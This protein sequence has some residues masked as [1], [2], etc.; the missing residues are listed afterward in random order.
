MKIKFYRLVVF[1]IILSS[2][3]FGIVLDPGTASSQ[4]ANR[5]YVGARPLGLGGSFAAVTNDANSIFWNPAGLPFLQRQEVT[6]M[7]SKLFGLE[8]TDSYIG[9]SYPINDNQ[10]VGADWFHHGYSDDELGVKRD[11]FH[12]AYGIRLHS[13]ISLGASAKYVG[14]NTSLDDINYGKA[15]GFGFDGGI[16]ISPIQNLKVGVTLMDIGGT[17][18]KYDTDVSEEI[19]RQQ[20]RFGMAYTPLDGLLVACDI[21]DRY[22]LG[23]E[24]WLFPNLALR[25]GVQKA[26]NEVNGTE[27]GIIT[28]FG[29]SFKYKFM[30]LDYAFERDPDLPDNHRFSFSFFFNPSLVSIKSAEVSQKPIYRSLYKYYEEQPDFAEV[31]IKN[32]SD[33]Q[34]PVQVSLEIP[35]VTDQPHVENIVLEPNSTKSYKLGISFS[36]N[37][38]STERASYDNMVQPSIKVSYMQE[39]QPKEAAQQL[40]SV[41]VLGKGK[42]SWNFPERVAA[43][44]TPEDNLIDEFARSNVQLYSDMLRETFDNSNFGKAMVLF[45]AL[46]KHGIVY[47]PDRQTPWY[48]IKNDSSILDNIQYPAELMDSKIGDCDDCAVLFSSLL[49]NLNIRTALLDVFKPGKGHIY[50]MF[51][52]GMTPAEAEGFFVDETEYVI[53]QDGVWIPVETTMFGFPFLDAWR[54]GAMEYHQMKDEGFINEIDLVE[55]KMKYKPGQVTRPDVQFPDK[56]TVDELLSV[57]I[58]SFNN[59]LLEKAKATGV[60]LDDPDGL[61]DAGVFYLRFNRL[62]DA[63]GMMDKAL[64]MKPDFGDAINAKGVILAKQRKYMEALPMFR[65]A[66]ELMPNEVGIRLNIALMLFL[67]GRRT[68]AETEFDD[69][70]KRDASFKEVIDMIRVKKDEKK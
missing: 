26:R 61:Y 45:D 46:G 32:S 6:S 19:Y 12:I 3:V 70:M 13:M 20:L 31:L 1:G 66:L 33:K 40:E 2:S 10:A 22:H 36:E 64:A 8:L 24:Y 49:E 44:V 41:Y 28:S 51:D 7:Y 59:R 62:N 53:F 35:T 58:E 50:M 42:I 29:S 15:S 67:S 47:N 68:D 55:P 56:A 4:V 65:R 48:K 39:K 11:I 52:A 25:S 21:D 34:L 37:I 60:S 9:Y 30:Q 16:I 14:T 23:A 38:L 18:V 17:S 43:F 69:I 27:R 63:M 54:N 57:D 5:H